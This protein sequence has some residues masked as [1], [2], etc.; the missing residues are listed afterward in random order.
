[1]V[2]DVDNDDVVVVV[3]IYSTTPFGI[4]CKLRNDKIM[5]LLKYLHLKIAEMSCFINKT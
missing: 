2:G 5:K 4:Y 1:M 3:F